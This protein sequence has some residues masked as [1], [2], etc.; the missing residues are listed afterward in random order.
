M[1]SYIRFLTVPH[2]VTNQVKNSE[3]KKLFRAAILG[4]HT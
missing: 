3:K 4:L 1:K 2:L